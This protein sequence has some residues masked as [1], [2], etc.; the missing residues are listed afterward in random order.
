[1]SRNAIMF[2]LATIIPACAVDAP[3]TESEAPD[4]NGVFTLARAGFVDDGMTWW[5]S[6]TGPELH[7]RIE[8]NDATPRALPVQRPEMSLQAFVGEQP[9][10]SPATIDADTWSIA[11]PEGTIENRDVRIVLRT[12]D[13]ELVQRFG[14]T[15]DPR[16]PIK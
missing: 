2:A 1:M 3:Q 7:G 14:Y 10:G 15:E 8:M 12:G 4:N 16:M 11:L 6:S 9:V 5:T 13:A